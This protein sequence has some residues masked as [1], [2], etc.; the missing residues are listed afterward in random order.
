MQLIVRFPP[1]MQFLVI[2]EDSSSLVFDY[3]K[4]VAGKEIYSVWAVC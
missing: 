3:H 4:N 2:L 1:K